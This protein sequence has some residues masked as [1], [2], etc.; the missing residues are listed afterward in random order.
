MAHQPTYE[1]LVQKV[2]ELE[3]EKRQAARANTSIFNNILPPSEEFSHN[4]TQSQSQADFD[5][6]SL[7]D[8]K[9]IQS[10]MD[11]FCALT[12]MVTAILDLNGKV[13]ESTGWQDICTKFH[14]IHPKTCHNC[15]E[16]DLYLA[17][18][19]KPG[20]YIGYKC[21]NGLWDVVTPLYIG[22]K[23]IGNIYTGQFFYDDEI[24]DEA[25][26]VQ[27]AEENGFDKN[28]YLEAFRKIPRY[29]STTIQNLMGF[30]VKFTTYISKICLSNFQL[31]REIIERQKAESAQQESVA[32]L[33][34]LIR[35]IPDLVW[36]KDRQG[37]Y[38]FCNSRFEDFFGASEND[39]VGKTD[40]DFLE[41]SLADFFRKHDKVA[42]ANAK[43]SKNEEEIVFAVDGHHEFLET[44]KTPLYTSS[45]EIGGVLG[46][47][48]DITDRK[49]AEEEKEILSSQ[50]QQ[51]QKMEA[52]GN[53]AGG[54]AHDFNNMLGVIIGHSEMAMDQVDPAHPL[55]ADLH[56]IRNAAERSAEITR[57][58][59]AFARK[60][61]ISLKILNLNETVE[62]MLK[63]LRRLIGEDI[64]LSWLPSPGLWQV[65]VDPSQID[66]ILATY[67]STRKQPSM[68]LEQF[69]L[70]QK[71]VI[72]KSTTQVFT[73]MLSQEN[74]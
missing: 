51:A 62:G 46:I 50:L 13:I 25:R 72:L 56:E 70:K 6:E 73:W 53:L 19:L 45:G 68:A 42:M 52:I 32:M 65:K 23:H 49:R 37:V 61:T 26:F 48:R 40:Y 69:L 58:L 44:I 21:K 24:V 20:E 71:T 43:P 8:V 38:L 14:R 30:L 12:G 55:F 60:Q 10:I 4:S 9:A 57:Q 22:H 47:G 28:A 17:K 36:L 39:I 59:L 2:S 5:L 64:E 35:A 1:E 29:N 15:T 7:I 33:R 54:V 74:M 63:M 41:S 31:E 67:V 34:S 66:Q 16:S 18:H 11:D 27:Q 3:N